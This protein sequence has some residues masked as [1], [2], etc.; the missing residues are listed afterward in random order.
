MCIQVQQITYIHPDKEVL[1][2]NLC[3]TVGKGRQLALIGNNGCG[4][5]T[6]LQIM[7][8]KLQPSS[9]NVLRPDDLYYVPQHFGQY[10]EMSI[11]QALGIDRKQKAL[12]EILNG[13]ASI[14]HFNILDDDWNIEEKALAALNGWGLGNRSLSESMH[15][16]SGGEKTR[17][18]LA[19]LELQ[20]PS[21]VLMDEPTN[22]LDNQGRNRLYEWVKKCRS[23][24]IVVSHDR[25]LLNRLPETCE[26]SRNALVC[27]GGNYEFYKQQKELQQNALQ[28]QLDEKEKELRQIRKLAREV[29]ERKEKQNIR[30]EK[31]VPKKG[32]S[33]M[34]VHTLKDRAEKSTTK[35]ADI[36]QNKSEKLTSERSLIRNRLAENTLLKTDFH[37]SA[38]H[39][40]KILM[41]AHEINFSYGNSPLWE[42]P[43]CFQLK[44]G[45]RIRIE[46]DNGS[47]KTTL[48]KLVTGDLLP[49]SGTL[50]RAGFSYVYL[51]QEYSI[52]CNQLTV[53]QQAESFNVRALPEHEIK[54][55]LNRFLFPATSW[56]QPC[57][58]LSGGE[59][60]RLAF[61]CLMISNNTPDLFILDEPTNNLDIQSIEIITA[62]VRNY[63]GSVLLVSHDEYF[64]KETGIRK[65]I[66]L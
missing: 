37:A 46:G 40:G 3:F 11:A 27:Y 55:R 43:L 45:D 22:H 61:C 35:L 5:S 4:K 1:F 38:L 52:I 62:T 58:Q 15:T 54:I 42:V 63:T 32:I 18:F 48:L 64:V 16:L 14:D 17:V 30:S 24:L 51:N 9:G 66:F 25:T 65:S 59:K 36:H 34:A 6:L 20:E 33:R 12:H 60:M 47:G 57:I 31:A 13:N 2:R 50:E 19:G 10:D 44:S 39:T 26:L 28:Q 29:A 7:A 56:D 8:G 53:L 23:T 41:T 49:T 21:A